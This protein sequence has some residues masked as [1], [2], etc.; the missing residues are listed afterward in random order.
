[1]VEDLWWCGCAYP[2]GRAKTFVDVTSNTPARRRRL[3]KCQSS[4]RALLHAVVS[5]VLGIYKCLSAE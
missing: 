4:R 3:A 1:V 5:V 2:P